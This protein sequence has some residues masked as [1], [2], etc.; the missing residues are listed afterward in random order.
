MFALFCNL[1]RI[2]LLMEPLIRRPEPRKPSFLMQSLVREGLWQL[3]EADDL[4]AR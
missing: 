2:P 3:T 4:T 1:I